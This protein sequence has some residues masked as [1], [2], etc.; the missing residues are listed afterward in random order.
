MATKAA[1]AEKMPDAEK[2]TDEQPFA[3]DVS[4]DKAETRGPSQ[5]HGN[6]LG[7]PEEADSSKSKKEDDGETEE[8]EKNR[9]HR[10]LFCQSLLEAE[11]VTK[12]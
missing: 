8:E 7:K 3:A 2:P 5:H 6:S 10:R 12:H 4:P 1:F 11:L 9:Q